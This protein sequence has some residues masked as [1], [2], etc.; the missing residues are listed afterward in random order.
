MPQNCELTWIVEEL[1]SAGNF[2]HFLLPIGLGPD[3]VCCQLR[4]ILANCPCPRILNFGSIGLEYIYIYIL[5]SFP[6]DTEAWQSLESS[7][8]YLC[9]ERWRA[10]GEGD[11]RGWDGWN[12]ITKSL[13][14]SLGELREVVMDREAWHAAV[15]GTTKS[16]TW[17]SNW[18]ELI[19]YLKVSFFL[20][21]KISF[22]LCAFYSSYSW[23]FWG[24]KLCLFPTFLRNRCFLHNPHPYVPTQRIR[25]A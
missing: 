25:I 13:D 10:G 16:R 11:D 6:A 22:S 1:S 17:L 14:M 23:I 4:W 19:L 24:S 21:L 20:Y 2:L 12:G 15:H 3:L 18:T 7:I 9:W 8:L 5:T